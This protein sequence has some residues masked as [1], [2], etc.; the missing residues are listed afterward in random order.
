[1][2]HFLVLARDAAGAADKRLRFR[3]DHIDY[4]LAQGDALLL[5]GAMMS[6]DGEEAVP[7]GSSFLLAAAGEQDIHRLIAGDP[8]TRH[9]VFDGAPQ[10]QRIRPAIGKLWPG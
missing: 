10:V 5:A 4:W 3:Q 6:G 8:F 1:M 2:M 7:V 9:G